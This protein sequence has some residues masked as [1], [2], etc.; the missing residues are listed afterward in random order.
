VSG[1]AAG[2]RLAADAFL[3]EH[4]DDLFELVADL[5]SIDSQIPPFADERR[6]VD[7]LRSRMVDLGLDEGEVLAADPV[8]PNLVTRVPGSSGEGRLVLNGHVDTKPVGDSLPLWESD[9]LGPEIRDGCLYGLGSSDMKGAV[10]AMVFAAAA[11]VASGARLEGDL[12]LA[13][14]ADEEAGAGLGSKFL[15]PRLADVGACLIGEPSGWDREWQGIHLVSRGVCC[16]RV[17][18]HGTQMHSSLSD[19]MPSVNASRRMADL[20]VSLEDELELEFVPHP[21]GGATPTLNVGV[22]VS[23]G[24]YFGVVPGLAEFGCDLRTLPGMTEA[25]VRASLERWLERRREADPELDAEIVFEPG[26]TWVPPAEIDQGHPLVA[27]A[28]A[29]AREVL[30]SSPPLSV[31]PGGTDAPWFDAAGVATIP[32]FGPGNLT[33]CHGPN[34]Y[35]SLESVLQAARMYARIAIDYCG[36]ASDGR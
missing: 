17:R 9:P 21:L 8:R 1:V 3:H 11:V 5:V 15:A 10:A 26:L 2:S 16:F 35:V 19:R 33:R 32:S 18:V 24:V 27:A 20:L 29:A 6:I 7:F 25:G 28:Q 30:G 23:G 22:L 4:R 12:V 34:E 31:F 14:V 36:T 13:F